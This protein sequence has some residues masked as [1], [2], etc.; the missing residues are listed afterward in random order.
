MSD[1]L[2]TV[3]NRRTAVAAV[4]QL[5]G[6]AAEQLLDSKTFYEAAVAMDVDA[7]DFHRRIQAIVQQ[8]AP[9]ATPP[10]PSAGTR[11]GEQWTEADVDAAS[12]AELAAAV[13]AGLLTGMGYMPRR[14]RR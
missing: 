4:R 2:L 7:P 12:P 11:S 3:I 6:A 14:R 13:E 5:A 1:D 9:Q 8:A 10:A